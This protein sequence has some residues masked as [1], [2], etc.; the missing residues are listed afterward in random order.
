MLL[1]TYH[2]YHLLAVCW[3]LY[4]LNLVEGW[5]GDRS[6]TGYAGLW[7]H[8][9]HVC[10]CRA[11]WWCLES[12]IRETAQEPPSQVCTVI[13]QH[14]QCVWCSLYHHGAL[15]SREVTLQ[16][17]LSLRASKLWNVSTVP[18]L[19]SSRSSCAK[20]TKTSNPFWKK[21]TL[22]A[23]FWSATPLKWQIWSMA[24]RW[25][26][27]TTAP[28]ALKKNKKKIEKCPKVNRCF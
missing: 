12:G 24:P 26:Q 22:A 23:V 25:H 11:S 6:G 27:G 9:W 17:K 4:V 2:S 8:R 1:M 18:N 5:R 20:M 10:G 21:P 16:Q 19:R 3:S 7:W 13:S 15:S 14:L 28:R